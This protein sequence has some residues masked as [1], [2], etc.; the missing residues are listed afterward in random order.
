[1]NMIEMW[2]AKKLCSD[3]C[4]FSTCFYFYSLINFRNFIS[5]FYNLTWNVLPLQFYWKVHW[6]Y[7]KEIGG[8]EIYVVFLTNNFVKHMIW[9]CHIKDILGFERNYALFKYAMYWKCFAARL[10]R[11]MFSNITYILTFLNAKFNGLSMTRPILLFRNCNKSFK[12]LLVHL[13][14]Y[15]NLG[16][17]FW[18]SIACN[19]KHKQ[20]AENNKR[21]GKYLLHNIFG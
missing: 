6:T 14:S 19:I 16:I 21:L 17:N 9:F 2:V 13:S 15:F 20:T 8:R 12:M 18:E 5:F 7:L 4:F 3:Y 11:H 1:M 10:R